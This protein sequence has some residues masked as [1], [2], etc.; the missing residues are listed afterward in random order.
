M[1]TIPNILSVLR[2]CLVP[3]FVAAY[4]LDGN[5]IKY[6]AVCIFIFANISD[7]LDGYIARKYNAISRLG[8]ILDP[9]GDK[10]L[11]FAALVCIT[12]SRPVLIWAVCAL[13]VKEVLMGVGALLIR[14]KI[15]VE[16]LSSNWLGKT[17]TVIFFA[18]CVLLLIFE[19]F[20][21]DT[22]VTIF[23]A[24]AIAAT[25]AAFTLYLHTFF[26]LFKNRTNT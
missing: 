16:P 20:M 1:K 2:I 12:I 22:L 21:S 23:A 19:S 3:V 25:L 5:D 10:L 14:K 24:V 8:K 9:L 26:T 18:V 7:I 17:A 6:F 15:S 13:F 4:L 11:F